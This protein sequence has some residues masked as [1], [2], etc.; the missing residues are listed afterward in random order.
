MESGTGQ[1]FSLASAR[2]NRGHTIRTLALE[3]ELD[4]RTLQR[5]EDGQPI[6]PA[7]ALK[8]ADYFGVQVTDLMAAE[9]DSKAAA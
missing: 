3:L 7:K 1:K 2:V 8:V 6:H 9:P 5:L 4:P